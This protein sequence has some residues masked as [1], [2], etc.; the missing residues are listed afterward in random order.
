MVKNEIF[1]AHKSASVSCVTVPRLFMDSL[2]YLSIWTMSMSVLQG[3]ADQDL[4]MG[5]CS[6]DPGW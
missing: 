3:N 6:G 5:Q 4:L 2:M 1:F